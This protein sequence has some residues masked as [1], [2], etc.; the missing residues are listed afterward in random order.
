MRK[1]ILSLATAAAFA[2]PAVANAQ[3]AAPAAAPA[4][5]H[6]VT[7][8]IALV[9]DYRFRGISQTFGQPALQGGFDYSHSSGFYL[10]NWNSN[11]SETAG[12]PNGNLE[13]DFYGGYKRAFGDFGL[14]LGAIYYYY[15]GTDAAGNTR[16]GACN[17]T[18]ASC[19]TGVVNNKEVYIGAS[20]KFLSAKYY[21]SVGD[22]FSLPA[23]KGSNYIDL[24]ATF[25]LGS[26]WGLV[27]H[28]GRM[29]V[30][31]LNGGSYTDYK[32]GITKDINGWVWGAAFVGTTAADNGSCAG[33]TGQFYHFCKFDT[34]GLATKDYQG[35][36]DTVVLSL[37]KSF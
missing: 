2:I 16:Y 27:G 21:H 24:T 31:D 23:T 25:D 4:S 29:N 15:P 7:G 18:T 36:K 19:G 32:V 37:T 28:G 14:D 13:M 12:F 1:S 20:W 11:I 17:P 35:G 5:P 33:G 34:A 30:K 10:G 3:T 9:T 26:G 22:Y 8:N 6:T